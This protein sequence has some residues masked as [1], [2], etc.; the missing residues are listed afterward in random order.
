MTDNEENENRDVSHDDKQKRLV[1]KGLPA[2]ERVSRIPDDPD[3]FDEEE[4][5]ERLGNA[6]AQES[7]RDVYNQ[8][9]GYAH[10]AASIEH[11]ASIDS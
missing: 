5:D 4:V 7:A 8:C 11:D 3:A 1:N 10:L 6:N 2:S 9:A